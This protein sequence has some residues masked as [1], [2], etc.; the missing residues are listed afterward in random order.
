LTY[1]TAL[2]WRG[3]CGCSY[4]NFSIAD[5]DF[6]VLDGRYF[7]ENPLTTKNPTMLGEEQKKWLFKL[8]KSSSATFKIIFTSVPFASKVSGK[9][10]SDDACDGYP[11]EREELY[12][13]IG[14]NNIS[15]VVFIA[16]DRHRADARKIKIP[17]NYDIYEFLNSRLTNDNGY[18][19]V[20]EAEGSEY[21]FGYNALPHF[22]ILAFDTKKED[23]ELTYR[24]VS[25]R[26][27]DSPKGI[28]F[29]L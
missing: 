19:L 6:F 26:D 29:V 13:F 8:I 3:L 27:E 17:G 20:E 24:V 16:G 10:L 7:R 2:V 9:E 22:G 23:P 1:K 5:V 4:K 21:L 15:G 12:R 11:E 14:E 25:M 28:A 18:R